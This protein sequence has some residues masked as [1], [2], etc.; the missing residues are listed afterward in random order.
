MTDD[1]PELRELLALARE[2]LQSE[3]MPAL[4]AGARFTAALIANALAIAG[5][6]L[7]DHGEADC[8]VADARDALTGFPDDDDLV[9]AIRSGAL[10]A[11]SPQRLAALTYATT[12]VQRRL[13]V[14]NPARLNVANRDGNG[15]ISAP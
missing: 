2:L 12:L 8:A 1:A 3:L 15:S 9:V 14:T 10:D 11:P 6:E 7:L 13:A 4:P 5:R